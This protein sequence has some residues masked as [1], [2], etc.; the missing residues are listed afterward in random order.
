MLPDNVL[1][2]V[3][4]PQ[5]FAHPRDIPPQ[6]LISYDY[7]GTALNDASSGLLVKVWRCRY[8]NGD[9][10]VDADQVPDTVVYSAP[11]VTELDLTF[12][13]NMQPFLA[14]V[15]AGEAKFRW[16][17][18]TVPGFVVTSL[19]AGVVTPR[20]ALDDKRLLQQ[21]VSDIVLAYVKTGDLYCR[22]QRDRFEV[23]YLLK[24]GAGAGLRRIGMGLR[25][26]FLFELEN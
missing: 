26:R 20:C 11:D 12:D 7:G 3:V 9:F 15:Q 10:I 4:V 19:G 21:N 16:Y 8:E 2:T 6:P 25:W 13:Q 23:E 14:F 24:A 17:D 22:Q 1:S 5:A 18:T